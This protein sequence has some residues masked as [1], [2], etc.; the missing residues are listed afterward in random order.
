[1]SYSPA[2][3]FLS[4]DKASF[5]MLA[6]VRMPHRCAIRRPV[7]TP[8]GSGG[9]VDQPTE[10]ATV[11]CALTRMLTP[12]E[13]TIGAGVAGVA[14]WRLLVPVDTDI[15]PPDEVLLWWQWEI[16]L[17]AP[18]AGEFSLTYQALTTPPI[19]FDA[20][21]ARVET[22]LSMLEG[23]GTGNVR[24]TGPDGG[25]YQVRFKGR[26]EAN[27]EALS[28]DFAALTDGDGRVERPAFGVIAAEEGATDAPQVTVYLSRRS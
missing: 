2:D 19:S 22:R 9:T 21:A 11:R 1:M 16:A 26:L 5:E 17:G 3:T 8:D 10:I 4:W 12:R 14:D 7:P 6:A 28:A 24:V 25:P 23:V 27:E 13:I 15:G 20:T 18:T